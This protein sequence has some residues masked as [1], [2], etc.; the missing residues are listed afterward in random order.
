MVR[1]P[2]PYMNEPKLRIVHMK[3]YVDANGEAYLPSE[4]IVVA[5]APSWNMDALNNPRSAYVP[6]A[7]MLPVGSSQGVTR[8]EAPGD[9]Q[10]T[11]PPQNLGSTNKNLL[12]LPGVIQT[13]ILKYQEQEKALALAKDGQVALFDEQLGWLLIPEK[14]L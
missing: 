8:F 4:K 3:A 1:Q 14:Y 7:M 10:Q 13:R 12:S 2:V 5:E 6:P 9:K 11:A